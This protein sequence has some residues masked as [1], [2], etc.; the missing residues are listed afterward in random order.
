MSV[1]MI[2]QYSVFSLTW[3]ASMEIHG[4]KESVYIRKEF[5]SHRTGLEHKHGC[6]FIVLGHK[7]GNHDV[8]WKT[9]YFRQWLKWC[10]ILI[11]FWHMINNVLISLEQRPLINVRLFTRTQLIQ[12]SAIKVHLI[13]W[14]NFLSV[15]QF[16]QTSIKR[17]PSIKR[18]LGKVLKV[19]A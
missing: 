15:A 10:A 5:N 3:P 6:R 16:L 14:H 18:T 4:T 17:T 8:M 19:S 11:T 9:Q 1:M 2:M 7:Y 13:V 12:R